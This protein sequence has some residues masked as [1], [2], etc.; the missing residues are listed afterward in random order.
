MVFAQE[1]ELKLGNRFSNCVLLVICTGRKSFGRGQILVKVRLES[2]KGVGAQL[3]EMN[4]VLRNMAKVWE[5]AFMTASPKALSKI[6]MGVRRLVHLLKQPAETHRSPFLNGVPEHSAM[7]RSWTT[8][9]E[10]QGRPAS[11]VLA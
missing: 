2:P 10:F 9:P 3:L 7:R 1:T 5:I 6:S 11:A 8:A 4:G